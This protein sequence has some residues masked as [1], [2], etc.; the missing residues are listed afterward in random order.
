MRARIVANITNIAGHGTRLLSHFR[1]AHKT[2]FFW[3]L[4]ESAP[5]GG[6]VLLWIARP[7]GN[8]STEMPASKY[9]SITSI[10]VVIAPLVFGSLIFSRHAQVA[11]QTPA[12]SSVPASQAAVPA[13]QLP[14]GPIVYTP[15]P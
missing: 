5:A 15:K 8:E 10:A 2:M 7:P 1:P 4:L 3:N 6:A 12:P 9:R 14:A 13:R 11:S